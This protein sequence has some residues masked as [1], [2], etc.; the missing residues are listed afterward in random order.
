MLARMAA[1]SSEEPRF[2]EPV[3]AWEAKVAWFM[4]ALAALSLAILAAEFAADSRATWAESGWANA[5]FWIDVAI[6][7][8][9]AAEFAWRVHLVRRGLRT[10]YV[11]ANPLDVVLALVIGVQ[12]LRL[13]RSA[14]ALRALRAGAVFGKGS[15]HTSAAVAKDRIVYGITIVIITTAAGAYAFSFFEGP[16][17]VNRFEDLADAFWWSATT[18]TTLGGFMPSTIGGR[19]VA[20]LLTMVGLILVAAL[21]ATIAAYFVESAP[22]RE[23]TEDATLSPDEVKEPGSKRVPKVR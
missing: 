1:T 21:A 18:I 22:P 10:R 16:K 4:L 12:P 5:L 2:G 9:F 19:I 17:E 7:T 15:K 14:R 8:I 3:A 13:A 11:L 20:L 23:T 6:M